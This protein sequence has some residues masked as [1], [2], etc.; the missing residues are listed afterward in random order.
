MGIL[1]FGQQVGSG[2][3]GILTERT[4]RLVTQKSIPDRLAYTIIN[5]KAI[6]GAMG[7]FLLEQMRVWD[8]LVT[9]YTYR[10]GCLMGNTI[11]GIQHNSIGRNNIQV[12]Y[13]ST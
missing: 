6:F 7:K 3:P 4:V 1:S 11:A 13:P 8:L 2:I 5:S 9:M 12:H 10:K